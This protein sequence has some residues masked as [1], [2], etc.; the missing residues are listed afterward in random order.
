VHDIGTCQKN[1][2]PILRLQLL[3]QRSF[4]LLRLIQLPFCRFKLCL[5]VIDV[6]LCFVELCA[7]VHEKFSHA[8]N[9]VM[10]QN[11]LLYR[12]LLDAYLNFNLPL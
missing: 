3:I 8:S 5:H 1:Y 12:E 2:L 6:G 4:F 10:V 11:Y 9:Y 7:G